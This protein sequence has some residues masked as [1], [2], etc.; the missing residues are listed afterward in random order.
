MTEK[1]E[2]LGVIKATANHPAERLPE[3]AESALRKA[4]FVFGISLL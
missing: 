2:R 4:T 1:S 3:T